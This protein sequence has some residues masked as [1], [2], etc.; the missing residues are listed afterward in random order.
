[1]HATSKPVKKDDTWFTPEEWED[2]VEVGAS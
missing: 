2:W 1:M